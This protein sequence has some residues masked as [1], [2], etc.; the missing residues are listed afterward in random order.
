MESEN[1]VKV[2]E[3]YVRD[4]ARS[5]AGTLNLFDFGGR[6]WWH[7]YSKGDFAVEDTDRHPLISPAAAAA[8]TSYLAGESPATSLP[9]RTGAATTRASFFLDFGM[10][11]NQQKNPEAF[12]PQGLR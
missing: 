11:V 6:E 12:L 8:Y 4:A 10:A 5:L 2:G 9:A 1:L 3:N 7:E